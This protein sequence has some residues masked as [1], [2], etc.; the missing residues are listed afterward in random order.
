VVVVTLL[1]S[2]TALLILENP[3]LDAFVPVLSETVDPAGTS[4]H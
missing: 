2:E 4:S 3:P 1:I